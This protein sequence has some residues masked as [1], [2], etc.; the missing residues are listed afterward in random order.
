MTFLSWIG[1]H[2]SQALIS[3]MWRSACTIR[4]NGGVFFS[5]SPI[6]DFSKGEMK[7]FP[8]KRRH[9]QHH[10]YR[11]HH[12]HQLPLPL[13]CSCALPSRLNFLLLAI[14]LLILFFILLPC[15][16]S[17]PGSRWNGT[18][19]AATKK[20]AEKRE[21]MWEMVAI[22]IIVTFLPTFQ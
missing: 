11:H 15:I 1:L 18:T 3:M 13:Q 2:F 7:S 12:C 4:C 6:W 8:W 20:R 14:Q 19:P 16:L 10:L 17:A 9:Y 5:S 21:R 22:I